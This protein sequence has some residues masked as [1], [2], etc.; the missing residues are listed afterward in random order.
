MSDRLNNVILMMDEVLEQLEVGFVVCNRCGDQED[1]KNL[2]FVGDIKLAKI[3]LI[4]IRE[5]VEVSNE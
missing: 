2:D 5:E 4:E 3:K 1:T